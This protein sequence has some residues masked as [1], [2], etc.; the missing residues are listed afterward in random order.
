[1]MRMAL[2]LK[3][4]SRPNKLINSAKIYIPYF[5][6]FGLLSFFQLI[7]AKEMIFSDIFINT[8][9][10]RYFCHFKMFLA[11]RSKIELNSKIL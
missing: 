6:P 9:K 4:R 3:V 11:L 1:M 8:Q 5:F 10:K 2:F 7:N